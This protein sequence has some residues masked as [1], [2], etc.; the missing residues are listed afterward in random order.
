VRRF[1]AEDLPVFRLA[2]ISKET[3]D[4]ADV[5]EDILAAVS[6]PD[7]SVALVELNHFTVPFVM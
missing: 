3:F 4:R 1:P 6:G 7:E 5:H 2:T